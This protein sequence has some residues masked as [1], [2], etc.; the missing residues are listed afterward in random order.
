M[1]EIKPKLGKKALKKLKKAERDSTKGDDWFNMKAPEMM[2]Q[3]QNEL[4]VL[5]MR[6]A[7]DPTRF[8]KKND[9]AVPPKYFQVTFLF[10]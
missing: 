10:F 7:I 2:P 3:L 1:H 6:A 4:D 8:Y 9:S 5:R